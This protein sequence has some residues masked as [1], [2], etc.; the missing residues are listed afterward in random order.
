[1]CP[2]YQA[3][4]QP[5]DRKLEDRSS[6]EV[7]QRQVHAPL[8]PWTIPQWPTHRHARLQPSLHLDLRSSLAPPEV[9]VV[10]FSICPGGM[11]SILEVAL[12]TASPAMRCASSAH[13]VKHLG[14]HY[15]VG[16]I[17]RP[18]RGSHLA[19]PCQIVMP[20]SVFLRNSRVRSLNDEE[21]HG[22]R[23]S[24]S[25]PDRAWWHPYS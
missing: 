4:S 12:V 14:P 3:D 18:P 21:F 15:C 25:P 11:V 2:T 24:R 13:C 6:R 20:K 10:A 7:C 16:S 17:Q 5:T 22:A 1:M 19:T 23:G 9:R 8:T